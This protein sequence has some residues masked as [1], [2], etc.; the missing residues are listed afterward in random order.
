M[1]K[2]L[3][4]IHKRIG[5]LISEAKVGMHKNENIDL[6]DKQLLD[7]VGDLNTFVNNWPQKKFVLGKGGQELEL[8]KIDDSSTSFTLSATVLDED[9]PKEVFELDYNGVKGTSF[10][11]WQLQLTFSQTD[12]GQPIHMAVEV[13]SVSLALGAGQSDNLS[14][15]LSGNL[16]IG[17]V[18]SLVLESKKNSSIAAQDLSALQTLL[19]TEL[20]S[21]SPSA[22]C[23]GGMSG[24]SVHVGGAL[25]KKAF[26]KMSFEFT[27]TSFQSSNWKICSQDSKPMSMDLDKVS[28]LTSSFQSGAGFSSS[29]GAL[30]VNGNLSFNNMK[31]SGSFTQTG[32]TTWKFSGLKNSTDSS[33]GTFPSIEELAKTFESSSDILNAIKGKF[34]VLM[35][36]TSDALPGLDRVALQIDLSQKQYPIALA[37]CEGTYESTGTDEN[38]VFSFVTSILPDDP[39]GKVSFGSPRIPKAASKETSTAAPQK[40]STL[41]TKV[42]LPNNLPQG[43]GSPQAELGNSDDFIIN[44]ISLFINDKNNYRF[45]ADVSVVLGYSKD[46][47]LSEIRFI[48]GKSEDPKTHEVTPIRYFDAVLNLG[49]KS[50]DHPPIT[51]FVAVNP[52]PQDKRT[53]NSWICLADIVFEE[54]GESLSKLAT[55]LSAAFKTDVGINVHRLK[56]SAEL[57]DEKEFLFQVGVGING[58]ET[59]AFIYFRPSP[60]L[61]V[62]GIGPWGF[63]IPLTKFG[64][65]FSSTLDIQVADVWLVYS[66]EKVEKDKVPN[67]LKTVSGFA[68]L[69]QGFSLEVGEVKLSDKGTPP[70]QK[71]EELKPDEEEKKPESSKT[72]SLNK[73]AWGLRM[74]AL[75]F[76]YTGDSVKVYVTGGLTFDSLV[77]ELIKAT[78]L[79]PLKSKADW[80]FSIEGF[81][82][83]DGD[84]KSKEEDPNAVKISGL[85]TS[86]PND[87]YAGLG[88]VAV[89]NKQFT[90]EGEAGSLPNSG[91]NDLT[92]FMALVVYTNIPGKKDAPP[93]G[94][95]GFRFQ[96]MALGYSGN[97]ALAVPSVYTMFDNALIKTVLG[98][99]FIGD[100][101]EKAITQL[102]TSKPQAGQHSLLI[103]VNILY[104]GQVTIVAM[105]EVQWGVDVRADVF[106]VLKFAKAKPKATPQDPKLLEINASYDFTIDFTH[107]IVSLKAILSDSS[108]IMEKVGK[109]TGG[110]AFYHWGSGEHH[111]QNVFTI[112]GYK[113]GYTVPSYFPS[114]PRL[115]LAINPEKEVSLVGTAYFALMPHCLMLGIDYK[116]TGK[117]KCLSIWFTAA[118]D[119]DIEWAPAHYSISADV[120]FGITV[121]IKVKV[122]FIH[123]SVSITLSIGASL[124]LEGPN[125]HGRAQIDL[126]FMTI[127]INFGDDVPPPKPITWLEMIEELVVKNSAQ[128]P[129][130]VGVDKAMVKATTDSSGVLVVNIADGLTPTGN[131]TVST[132]K[133][134]EDAIPMVDPG[135]LK[136]SIG[137]AIPIITTNLKI[138]S[139]DWESTYT[140]PA[141]KD[142][143]QP[144][145]GAPK[146]TK[147][148]LNLEIT[149]PDGQPVKD[150][151]EVSTE[152][153]GVPSALWTST[154]LKDGLS[155]NVL[156][157]LQIVPP[158]AISDMQF[159][160]DALISTLMTPVDEDERVSFS[161]AP[162]S[163]EDAFP[164][165]QADSALS[166]INS[167]TTATNRMNLVGELVSQGLLDTDNGLNLDVDLIGSD[168]T[169][170]FSA[171]PCL[172]EIGNLVKK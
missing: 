22:D 117:F 152:I 149:G 161:D 53:N 35:D 137:S 166:K 142:P 164:N 119:V 155:T 32:D 138:G 29:T 134:S 15:D 19:G 125:L 153:A 160:A 113:P 107:D 39:Y 95:G 172:R 99:S 140:L 59:G 69:E 170:Y 23:F 38:L 167:T 80:D 169:T 48:A 154:V 6:A 93:V 115:V 41:L 10:S 126:D 150:Q 34:G 44:N 73:K 79:V 120:T 33:N 54:P 111:G 168:P 118:I 27:F 90:L 67:I 77:F 76:N 17:S 60:L 139:A 74:D 1:S 5:F 70:I 132:P 101:P 102:T 116:A 165:E 103:G 105:L 4:A 9:K 56:L 112:G 106:G 145:V 129:S 147:S 124:E 47:S 26:Q 108:Y 163:T 25:L 88:T 65:V 8:S 30:S 50:I 63:N 11:N 158:N 62:Y 61:L 82:L 157:G 87:C 43:E 133:A 81:K 121:S 16:E 78:V 37:I 159:S 68:E 109:V 123:V 156:T 55:A 171:Q 98:D 104:S 89:G 91:G 40:L 100:N 127:N 52:D 24:A 135:L 3:S 148:D 75:S 66:N 36:S 144:E 2:D 162:F 49:A 21:T 96:G 143:T 85:F 20:F 14:C 83:T 12:S 136:I 57:G 141:L 86:I 130:Q 46:T 13:L 64:S 31:A 151:W 84:S 51:V 114:V 122:L 110:L 7:Q 71:P 92:V 146:L 42:G 45:V 94:G 28:V 58:V 72:V 18:L 131:P 128:K 97:L